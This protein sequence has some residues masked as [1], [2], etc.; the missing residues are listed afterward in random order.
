MTVANMEVAETTNE[1][2]RRVR[3][4]GSQPRID[5]VLRELPRHDLFPLAQLLG[6]SSDLVAQI[7]FFDLFGQEDDFIG[8]DIELRI[9]EFLKHY[10]QDKYR[11]SG[12]DLLLE[13]CRIYRSGNLIILDGGRDIYRLFSNVR[14]VEE[15]GIHVVQRDWDNTKT[16]SDV[17]LL[18]VPNDLNY[19][20]IKSDPAKAIA[21]RL[22]ERWKKLFPS[23]DH[24]ELITRVFG[25]Q[26]AKLLC[27]I[28][29]GVT[30]ESGMDIYCQFDN[31]KKKVVTP[32]GD[33]AHFE[34][35][36]ALVFIP[37]EYFESRGQLV[38]TR[39]R[40]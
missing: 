26:K 20:W 2:P 30:K 38:R 9:G 10:I 24:K 23:F 15:N 31:D 1:A 28:E 3:L 39:I 34:I 22:F 11:E 36:K 29:M 35:A 5:R 37:K 21:Y 6:F 33:I 13:F 32:N 14:Y 7:M 8:R 17:F 16:Q 19:Y 25:S 27:N 12:K 18:H 40:N 4:D